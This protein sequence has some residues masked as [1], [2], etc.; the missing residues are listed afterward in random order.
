MAEVLQPGVQIKPSL[1][2]DGARALVERLYGVTV[3]SIKEME[4]YDDKNYHIKVAEQTSNPNL[5]KLWP[6]GYVFKVLN[7]MDS[8]KVPFVEA[9][10]EM[11]LCLDTKG[12]RCTQPVKN[13]HGNYYSVE[14]IPEVPLTRELCREGGDFLARFDTALEDFSHPAYKEHS[15]IWALSSAVKLPDFLFAVQ[16]QTHVQLVR[17]QDEAKTWH[18]DGVLDFGDTQHTCYLFE[19]AL[20]ACYMMLQAKPPFEPLQAAAHTVAGYHAMR[21]LSDLE[22]SLIQVCVCTRLCQS[23]VLGAY[24]YSQ[25][26]GNEYVLQTAKSGSGWKVLAD[27]WKEPADSFLAALRDGIANNK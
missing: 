17:D 11:M 19:V 14:K 21:P 16:D 22:L 15:T 5:K 8:R 1:S 4:A 26:P 20:A 9:Q 10:N 3:L 24:S 18:V 12:I 23:L 7:S 27:A 25:D 2:A 6:H 13:I